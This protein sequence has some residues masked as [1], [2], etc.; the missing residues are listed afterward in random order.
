MTIKRSKQ[1][2]SKDEIIDILKRNVK[3]FRDEEEFVQ[4]IVDLALY[5]VQ[6][7]IVPGAEELPQL[8]Q[9]ENPNI[10]RRTESYR[11]THE[12]SEEA[13]EVLKKHSG[14]A[15]PLSARYCRMCGAPTGGKAI[16]PSCGNMAH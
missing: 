14:K 5:L 10:E 9:P 6:H 7:R 13:Y 1:K 15:V 16:C 11:R 12:H 2:F 4:Y 8:E 3:L